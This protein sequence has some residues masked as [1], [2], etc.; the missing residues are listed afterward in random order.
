VEPPFFFS[1]LG[2]P[3]PRPLPGGEGD[4]HRKTL[5]PEGKEG[6]G[7]AFFGVRGS[8]G[9]GGCASILGQRWWEAP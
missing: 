9:A 4:M 8:D 1:H 3:H 6:K 2:P 7:R 5:S